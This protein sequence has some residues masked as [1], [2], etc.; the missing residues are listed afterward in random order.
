MNLDHSVGPPEL[1]EAEAVELWAYAAL[2]CIKF[3]AV[4]D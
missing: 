3:I 1:K 4:L 2:D